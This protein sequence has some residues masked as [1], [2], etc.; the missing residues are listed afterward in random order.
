MVMLVMIGVWLL[1]S[2]RRIAAG[3]LIALAALV[4]PY[5]IVILPAC[6]KPWDWRLPVA[7]TLIVIACY[8]PYIGVGQGVLGFLSGYLSEEGFQGGQGFWLVNVARH[9][10]GDVPGLQTLYIVFAAGVLGAQALRMAFTAEASPERRMRD[11]AMLLMAGLFFLSPNYPW[12]FLVVVP[13]IPIGGGTPAWA[14]SIGALLLYLLYPD[15]TARFLI[16]KGVISIAFLLAVLAGTSW[17]TSWHAPM[18]RALR[19]TR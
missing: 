19:W 7:V 15:Y 3:I 6:W 12:Y 17:R 2:S 14:L 11:I 18:E 13:F 8:L 4:K 9:V 16:W 5:A 1:V 10:F